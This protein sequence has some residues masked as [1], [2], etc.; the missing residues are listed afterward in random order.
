MKKIHQ[1]VVVISIAA[2]AASLLL[3]ASPS[4]GQVSANADEKEKA[5]RAKRIAE[6]FEA[7]ARV[8]TVFDRQGKVLKTVGE[9]GLYD[10][11][12]FSPDRTRLAVIKGDLESETE[13]LWVLEIAAGNGTRIT[14]NK[15]RR[16]EGLRPG[17]V[18]SPDG[19]QI[20]YVAL[21]GGYWSLCRKASSGEG[22]EEVLYQYPGRPTVTDW[23]MDG[24][25]DPSRVLWKLP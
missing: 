8:L 9:R 6:Q 20:A 5:L 3:I 1:S 4:R 16:Q 24:R 10:D 18:W 11:P 13:D 2:L 23:S 25:L 17:P 15:N 21:R 7:Q 12:V 19:R 14:S 22:T